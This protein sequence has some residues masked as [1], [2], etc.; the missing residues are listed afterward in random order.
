MINFTIEEFCH[1]ET[2]QQNGIDNTPPEEAIE[3][4]ETL[5][6]EILDPLREILGKPVYIRSG[7][8]SPKLNRLVGGVP[9]SQHTKGEAADIACSNNRVLFSII[10]NNFV[11]DQLID[12][13]NYS[14]IHV[15]YSKSKNRNQI[16]HL[17]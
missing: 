1:S 11:F 17:T 4:I 8:R 5:V 14:W 10:K 12:E 13:K 3:N 9:T 2:A 15:S 6:K 16:L 7:Y